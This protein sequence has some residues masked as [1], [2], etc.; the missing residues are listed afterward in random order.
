[1]ATPLV[2][3]EKSLPPALVWFTRSNLTLAQVS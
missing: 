1:V 2:Q 3:L